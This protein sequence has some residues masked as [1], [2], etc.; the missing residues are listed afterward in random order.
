MTNF[1][2]DIRKKGLNTFAKLAPFI[3]VQ[4]AW[5]ASIKGICFAIIR[6]KDCIKLTQLSK[7]RMRSERKSKSVLKKLNYSKKTSKKSRSNSS[8]KKTTL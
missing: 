5:L 1:V 7:R 4:N 2:S 6:S 8:R 3:F